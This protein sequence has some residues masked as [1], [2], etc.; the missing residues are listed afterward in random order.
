MEGNLLARFPSR[1][2][3]FEWGRV[4]Q[5][6][7]HRVSLMIGRSS[8]QADRH[9]PKQNPIS[10]VCVGGLIMDRDPD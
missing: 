2:R 4:Y 3:R 1:R 7:G 8:P 10:V 9:P 6:R 5:N